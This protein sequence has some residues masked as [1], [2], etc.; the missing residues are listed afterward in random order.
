MAVIVLGVGVTFLWLLVLQFLWAR[1]QA[2][3]RRLFRGKSGSMMEEVI[4]QHGEELVVLGRRCDD[5]D[6]RGASNSERLQRAMSRVHLIR[7]NLFGGGGA[8]QSFS[9]ALL[10]ENGDG[11]VL[12][13]LQSGEGGTRVYGKAISKGASEY[14]LSPEEERAITEAMNST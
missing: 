5:A 6:A 12:S 11:V 10:D 9:L 4:S 3:L 1:Q 7:F 13:S 14:R 8:D 2:R